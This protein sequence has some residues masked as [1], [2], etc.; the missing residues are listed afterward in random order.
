MKVRV[1][2]L[3]RGVLGLVVVGFVVGGLSVEA[4][5]RSEVSRAQ[6]VLPDALARTLAPASAGEAAVEQLAAARRH[7][8]TRDL[9]GVAAALDDLVQAHPTPELHHATSLAYFAAGDGLLGARNAQLAA[10]L[11]PTDVDRL[12]E[13]EHAVDVALAWRVRPIS[14]PLGVIGMIGLAALLVSAGLRRR[15][16]RRLE[17]F[18]DDVRGRIVF[19]TDGGAE[20]SPVLGRES[21][22]LIVDVFLSGRYGMACPRRPGH[23]PTLHLAFSHAGTSQTLRLRPVRRVC[24]SAVRV[25][26]R[27][28][29]L[30]TLLATEG[31][32][33]LHARLANRLVATADLVVEHS[34]RNARLRPAYAG[35]SLREGGLAPLR[36]SRGQVAPG[37]S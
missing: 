14:R 23:S 32:W 2:H 5:T 4:V 35:R 22:A 21:E 17:A 24:D 20:R 34:D 6:R 9:A 15:H 11:A 8:R 33:R 27:D 18:L 12:E 31:R 19:H 28:S 25:H 36:P 29:T 7:L 10:R 13:A 3:G 37:R 26:V 1:R 16:R 30:R